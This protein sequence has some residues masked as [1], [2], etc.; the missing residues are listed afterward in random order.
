MLARLPAVLSDPEL[1]E[2]GEL[3]VGAPFVDGKLSAGK[4][5]RAVKNNLEVARDASVLE[6]LNRIVMNA[7]VAH[8]VYQSAALPRHVASPFYVRYTPGMSYGDHVDDPLMGAGPAYRS[9]IAITLFLSSP[10]DYQGGELTIQTALGEQSVKLPAGDAILYPASRVHRVNP[11]TSGKRVVAV[12]W[13]Q[14]R[15]R[16]ADRRELLYEIGLARDALMRGA[17]DAEETRRIDR[18]Y[19]NLMRMWAEA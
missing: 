3:L 6:A 10:D 8:P 4:L 11:I 16:E 7:L 14:S 18:A 19:V 12:T 2:V 13:V 15:V 17:P 9:D 5:A 1:R